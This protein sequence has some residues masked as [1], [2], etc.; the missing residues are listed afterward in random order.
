MGTLVPLTT[1]FPKPQMVWTQSWKSAVQSISKMTSQIHSKEQKM[2]GRDKKSF[3]CAGRRK[4]YTVLKTGAESDYLAQS[5]GS[6]HG[7]QLNS[8]I[9]TNLHSSQPQAKR[10]WNRAF[11]V[12]S[13]IVSISSSTVLTLRPAFQPYLGS[14]LAYLHHFSLWSSENPAQHTPVHKCCYTILYY[15]PYCSDS[16]WSHVHHCAFFLYQRNFQR[17]SC[18]VPSPASDPPWIKICHWLL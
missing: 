4:I 1:Q 16:D 7:N 2:R 15:T 8:L 9:D 17:L 11:S 12:H 3:P 10:G 18:T 6:D 13:S 14:Y 5:Y